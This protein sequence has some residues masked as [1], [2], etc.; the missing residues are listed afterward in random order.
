MRVEAKE[1]GVIDDNIE[2][3]IKIGED[4]ACKI[5]QWDN[6]ISELK[7]FNLIKK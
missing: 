5:C 3:D 6:I 1:R 2:D 4:N 7:E